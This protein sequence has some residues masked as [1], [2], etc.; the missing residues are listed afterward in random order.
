M[1]SLHQAVREYLSMRRALGFKLHNAGKGLLD[2]VTFLQQQRASYIT[3]PLALAWSKQH[4]DGHHD[5]WSAQRLSWVRL[6]AR[7]RSATDPRT[8]IPPSGLLPYRPK[9]ARPY[10]YSD[11]E[12][13]QLLHATLNMPVSPHCYNRRRCAFLRWVYYGLFGLLS[14]SGLR[15]SEARNLELKDV[16]LK[17]GVLTI[18]AGKFGK[19]RLLPLHASTCKVLADYILRRRRHWAGRA[20]S[21]YLFVSSWGNRLD[22]GSIHR[23]FYA[24]SRPPPWS[25]GTAAIRIRSAACHS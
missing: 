15:L 7:Y 25:T 3:L 11:K 12:I 8:Q 5:A 24:D 20:V 21:S 2:F 16:D 14:V 6:F 22:V 19:D 9:R 17:T 1:N 4:A 23:A 10:L 13:R 18:R